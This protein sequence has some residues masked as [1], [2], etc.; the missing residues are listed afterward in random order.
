MARGRLLPAA[1]VLALA[2]LPLVLNFGWADRSYDYA[3]RD[4]AHNL[5]ESVEPYGVLFTVG[6][7]DT[8]PLWYLQEVE[9]IRRDVTVIVT[10]YLNTPWYAR[11]LRDLSR[12]CDDPG[13][14]EGAP[15]RIVCQREYRPGP[16]AVYAAVE[17]N[18]D[19]VGRARLTL[20]EPVRR[21]ALPIME[22]DDATIDRVAATYLWLEQ[23]VA[24]R[25][26][27]IETIIPGDKILESW[28]Q[29]ALAIVDT[30]F[31]DDRPVYWAANHGPPSELGLDRHLVRH[32]VVFKLHNGAL[33]EHDGGDGP[34]TALPESPV[35]AGTGRWLDAERTR[36]LL[37]EVYLHRSGLP[38]WGHWPDH[39]TTYSPTQY[40]WAYQAAS[41][42]EWQAGDADESDRYAGLALSWIELAQ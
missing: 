23:D 8:F 21:P 5:L 6:D 1:P 24:A 22:L 32:G 42:A 20:P 35:L 37:D 15:T 9:G 7:N 11:Q 33:P 34:I 36:A 39:A 41:L 12:P 2:A 25:V 30:A 19:P 31:S 16:R 3:A 18:V 29:F 13:A 38:H 10:Q 17:E 4:W 40:A 28:H 14:A 27:D 26:G